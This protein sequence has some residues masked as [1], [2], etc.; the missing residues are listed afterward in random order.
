MMWD[1]GI[2]R[3]T[4]RQLHEKPMTTKPKWCHGAAAETKTAAI[5][6]GTTTPAQKKRRAELQKSEC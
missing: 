4:K 1:M 2:H 5:A 6:A 3:K